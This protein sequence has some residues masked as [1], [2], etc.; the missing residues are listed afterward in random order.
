MFRKPIRIRQRDIT[1]CGAACIASVAAFYRL[2]IPI[3][4]IR[5]VAGTDKQGTNLLGLIEAAESLGFKAK[6][7]K[8]DKDSLHK[9]PFPTIAHIV[10][11][12]GLHHYIVI[13]NASKKGIEY[14]DPIDGKMHKVSIDHFMQIWSGVLLLLIP[15]T[16]FAAGGNKNSHLQRFLFLI[17]PYQSQM[18]HALVGA[19]LYTVLGLT[20]SIYV[21]KIVDQVLVNQDLVLL[22]ILSIGMIVILLLQFL[23]GNIKSVLA[24]QTGQQIDIRLIL[25]YYKHLLSLPM[26][27]FDSMR[28]GE[29]LSRLNDAVKIRLFINDVVLGLIVNFFILLFSILLMLVY[30]RTMAAL[31]VLIIP[32]Y[33]LLYWISNRLNRKWQRLL[34]EQSAEL[35]NQLVE[36]ID[37]VATIKRFALEDFAQQK[38]ENRFMLLMKSVYT[39]GLNGIY[40]GN[41]TEFCT[42]LFTITI[43]WVG[44]YLAI[45][46]ELT[47]GELLSFYALI[48]Y[49]TG[50]VASLIDANK[51]IQD[52][53]IAADRLFEIIDLDKEPIAQNSIELTKALAGDIIFNEVSFRYGT[54]ATIFSELSLKITA[55][56]FTAIV[57]ESGSGKSTLLSLLQNMYTLQKGSISIGGIDI[58]HINNNSLRNMVS[59]VPQKIDLFAG[60]IVEN[61]A[62]GIYEP[63]LQKILTITQVLGMHEFIEKLPDGYYTL[64]N[65]QGENLSGGQRQRLAIARAL[66]TNPEILIL[67]EA[68][69]SLDTASEQKIQ[70]GLQWFMQQ[71]KTI[72]IIAHRLSTIKYCDHIIVLK[73]S[74]VA[75]QGNHAELMLYGGVYATL[76]NKQY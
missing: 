28:T 33:I 51:H 49:F 30:N 24:L 76:Y 55:N 38:T 7:A 58:K 65:E 8:G 15:G 40:I 72:I 4:N 19:L 39:S 44:C 60:T 35:E 56:K 47:P 37:A 59:V 41:T 54:R 16:S 1:D 63:D 27:F 69:S 50:P 2:Y 20:F 12:S 21:Q 61:I 31:V 36:S 34:M 32:V 11:K 3:S 22:R 52:A 5:L 18:I 23:L 66:Y 26:K 74:K 6:A 43:L 13:Y 17:K 46:K 68:T 29:L 64:L 48:G 75:E 25:G 71:Q 14:M 42:K 53:V 9:I 45:Q 73:D 67:D 70:E 57:G 62:V 10:L